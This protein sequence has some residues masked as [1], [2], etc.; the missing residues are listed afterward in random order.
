VTTRLAMA[1]LAAGNLIAALEDRRPPALLNPQ[2]WEHR[3]PGG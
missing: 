1:D 3:S 2:V